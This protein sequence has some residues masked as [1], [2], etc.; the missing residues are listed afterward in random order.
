MRIYLTEKCNQHC[1]TCFNKEIR[2]D[3]DIDTGLYLKALDTLFEW[4]YT[5]LSFLGGEPLLHPDFSLIYKKTQ[6]K[7]N[8]IRTFTNGTVLARGSIHAREKDSMAYNFFF[9]RHPLFVKNVLRAMLEQGFRR[10]IMNVILNERSN[11]TSIK[12]DVLYFKEKLYTP[13]RKKE[14]TPVFVVSIDSTCD[15]IKNK[16]QLSLGFAYLVSFLNECGF[17]IEIWQRFPSCF[18]AEGIAKFLKES[19][20]HFGT[21]CTIDCMGLLDVDFNL[22]PCGVLNVLSRKRGHEPVNFFQQNGSP[23]SFVSFDREIAKIYNE[24]VKIRSG[25]CGSCMKWGSTCNMGCFLGM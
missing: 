21:L 22:Q 1:K 24:K 10:V 7:I 20:N 19:G 9:V 18:L 17:P 16:S 25:A 8:E 15:I 14:I 11:I 2:R 13:A 23:I 4:G 3:K 6:E 12:D 5:R